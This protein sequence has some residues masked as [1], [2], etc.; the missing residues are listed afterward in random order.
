MKKD[1]IIMCAVPIALL[2]SVMCLQYGNQ[3]RKLEG[4]VSR[5]SVELA[6]AQIPL[7]RDTIRDSIEVVTQTVVEVVPKKLKEALAADQQLIKELQL[8]VK[9]LEAMQTTVIETHDTVPAQYQAH[10]SLF[11]YSDQWA[12][13]RLQ[14]KDTTFY[15]NIRDSLATVVYREYKHRFL[16]WKWGT[17]GYRLKIVN[18]NP[19]SRVTYNKYIRAGK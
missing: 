3:V 7:Q 15:Y 12:D 13:L 10:D 4:E 5:L 8:K 9:Q 1:L 2:V 11:Y 19:H 14:L 18:F 6:H 17:K 16:W